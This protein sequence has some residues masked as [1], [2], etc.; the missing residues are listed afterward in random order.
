MIYISATSGIVYLIIVVLLFRPEL[1]QSDPKLKTSLYNDYLVDFM[2]SNPIG[3][4]GVQKKTDN[5][6][7]TEEDN[8]T[9]TEDDL[10]KNSEDTNETNNIDERNNDD[11]T[12][13]NGK[14]SREERPSRGERLSKKKKD[15]YDDNDYG[16]TNNDSS[17]LFSGLKIPSLPGFPK[18]GFPNLSLGRRK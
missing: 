15:K 12:E 7:S 13:E 2:T 3:M 6:I 5:V 9:S 18:I 4:Q 10:I 8:Q 16:F 14:N 17:G 1:I 11:T